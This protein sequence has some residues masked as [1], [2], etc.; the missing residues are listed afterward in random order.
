MKDAQIKRKAE[1]AHI[2]VI[3]PV[4]HVMVMPVLVLLRHDFGYLFLRPKSIFL[5]LIWALL[6]FAVYS[7]FESTRWSRG[8]LFFWFCTFSAIGYVGHLIRAMVSQWGKAQHDQFA[9]RSFLSLLGLADWKVF[10]WGEPVLVLVVSTGLRIVAGANSLSGYLLFAALA[11]FAKEGINQWARVRKVKQQADALE[12]TEDT[13]TEVAEKREPPPLP[14]SVV[15]TSRKPRQ[16]RSRVRVESASEGDLEKYAAM[17]RLIPP[18]SL[19]QAEGNYKALVRQFHPDEVNRTAEQ[20]A[21]LAAL[22][23]AIGFFRTHF[24][25]E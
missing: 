7:L 1:S 6:L 3:S 20:N 13:M 15:G 9:G 11:M 8:A 24:R 14:A 21:S 23:E 17:L 10:L 18:Y 5:A 22:N 25:E 12:D 4:L 2:P 19:Q 16:Q